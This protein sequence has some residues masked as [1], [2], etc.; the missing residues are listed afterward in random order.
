MSPN[1]HG[2]LD[3]V[4]NG[5]LKGW[6]FDP[7][8]PGL[9]VPLEFRIDGQPFTTLTASEYRSDL[10][11]A[12][13]GDGFHAYLVTLPATLLD[14]K[15]HVV[16]AVIAGTAKPLQHSPR[17]GVFPSPPV[18]PSPGAAPLPLS[19]AQAEHPKT[20]PESAL[21]GLSVV[22]ATRNHAAGVE[23]SLQAFA[24]AARNLPVEFIVVDHG[25]ED[26]TVQRLQALEGTILNL[27]WLSVAAATAGLARNHGAALAAYQLVLFLGDTTLPSVPTI[28]EQ[29][30]NAHRM[31]PGKNVAV[32]GKVTWPNVPDDRV[33][34][35]MAHLQ[36]AGG[37][38]FGFHSLVPYTWLDWRFFHPENI[39]FKR[40]AVADWSTD[41][42]RT[43]PSPEALLE[44]AELAYRLSQ[45]LEGGLPILYFPGA[46][47][48]HELT[49]TVREYMEHQTAAGASAY[50]L[51][52]E[53]SGA[54]DKLGVSAVD[55]LLASSKP[56]STPV[57]EDLLRMIEG[58][59]SWAVVIE[60]NYKL[61]SQ[62]WHAD[63]LTAVFEL[64]Y[65]QGYV[66]GCSDPQANYAAAYRYCLERF[67][68]RL[69]TAAAFEAFGRFPSFT[70]T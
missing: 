4:E 42:Y 46:A 17:T 56:L 13:V 45:K 61:G 39:S 58:A 26:D 34:F 11:D 29:H 44:D 31:L 18:P 20:L 53:H 22:I 10:F 5:Q 55:R 14:G 37:Q 48:T 16:E 25:S 69:A 1:A 6:A 28:F 70:V 35:L 68:E 62:N 36:G 67:Q 27:R 7:D 9:R 40:A 2:C 3:A 24:K 19:A 43:Q 66:L 8:T 64:S 38:Q 49:Y 54:K 47:V 63:L 41:G 57:L 60:T 32:L 23:R 15:V 65:L 12:G 59:K 30:I 52:A 33:S 51:F 50:K 21:N